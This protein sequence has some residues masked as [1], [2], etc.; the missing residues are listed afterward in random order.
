VRLKHCC[1][2]VS[3]ERDKEKL[4]LD[5]LVVKHAG[6]EETVEMRRRAAFWKELAGG[7][8]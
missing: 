5:G 2:G 8:L 1:S 4:R 6:E 7:D 3:S